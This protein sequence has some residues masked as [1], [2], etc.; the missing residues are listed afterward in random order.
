MDAARS[1]S[2]GR[3][4][5]HT[6]AAAGES[7]WWDV[8]VSPMRNA[9]G[10]PTHLLTVAHDITSAR[11]HADASDLLTLELEHRI[12]NLFALVNGLVT[13]AARG[14]CPNLRANCWTAE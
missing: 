10:T 12:K 11:H 3:F 5:G 6:S 13:L 1:G 7:E 9:G 2:V 4:A 14:T 8:T